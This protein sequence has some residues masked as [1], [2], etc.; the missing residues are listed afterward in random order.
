[1]ALD[2]RRSERSENSAL[3]V[4]LAMS[5]MLGKPPPDVSGRE[6]R[7]ENRNTR[8]CGGGENKT[9]PSFALVNLL[10]SPASI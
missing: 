5:R 7:E 9:L 3:G 6:R 1:M 10:F 4:R 8:H 2:A